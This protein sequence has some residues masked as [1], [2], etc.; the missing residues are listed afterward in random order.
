MT[1]YSSLQIQF[2]HGDQFIILRGE[3]VTRLDYASMYQLL[4]VCS[5]KAITECYTLHVQNAMDTS[6]TPIHA[7]S[8]ES[9][10]ISL[11]LPDIMPS[12][13]C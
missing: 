1:D 2:Y 12:D 4:R 7:S 10:N 9:T 3:H 6:V 5:T 11:C 13:L 8:A